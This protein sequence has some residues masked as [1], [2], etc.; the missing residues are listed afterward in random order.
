MYNFFSEVNIFTSDTVYIAHRLITNLSQVQQVKKTF[1]SVVMTVKYIHDS[2][3]I[4]TS[5]DLV[6]GLHYSAMAYQTKAK[7]K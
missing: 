7:P 4:V 2:N 6:Y 5:P 3:A 1:L